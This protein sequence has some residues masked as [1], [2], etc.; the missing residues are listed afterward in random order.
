M[1][2]FSSEGFLIDAFLLCGFLM[3]AFLF[4]KMS[5]SYPMSVEQF[6]IS[7]LEGTL[8]TG[9]QNSFMLGPDVHP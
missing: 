1:G 6:F 4:A 5:A 3:D 7:S 8:L 9:V 2:G